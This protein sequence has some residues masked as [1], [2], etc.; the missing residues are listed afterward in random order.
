MVIIQ[1][2]GRVDE[3]PDQEFIADEELIMEDQVSGCEFI[4]DVTEFDD[5]QTSNYLLKHYFIYFLKNVERDLAEVPL[6]QILSFLD[7]DSNPENYCQP[8]YDRKGIEYDISD[9]FEKRTQKFKDEL[10]IFEKTSKDSLYNAVL[11]ALIFKL[12]ER[13]PFVT[14]DEE[15]Q[16]IRAIE[17]NRK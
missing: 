7:E 5:Q 14:D 9:K 15:I 6:D 13:K 10:K 2:Y 17:K 1:K 16:S 11:F 3:D 8:E 12:T 4:D